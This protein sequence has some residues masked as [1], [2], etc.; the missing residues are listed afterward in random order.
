MV[1]VQLNA[2]IA[3]NPN[4]DPDRE[5]FLLTSPTSPTGGAPPVPSR[6]AQPAEQERNKHSVT[7][8][9]PLLEQQ[10]SGKKLYNPPG[11]KEGL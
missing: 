2:V 7:E 9:I 11:C 10:H 6:E 4:K 1:E 8:N 5:Y 3:D